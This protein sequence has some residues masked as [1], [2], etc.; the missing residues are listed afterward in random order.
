MICCHKSFTKRKNE[1]KK[2]RKKG[3]RKKKDLVCDQ[4]T[5]AC[6]LSAN[7]D[8]QDFVNHAN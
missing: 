4:Y 6:K 2:C 1:R 7:G 8:G 3:R 5:D